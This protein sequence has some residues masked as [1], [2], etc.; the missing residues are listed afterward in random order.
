MYLKDVFKELYKKNIILVLIGKVL[1]EKY[2]DINIPGVYHINGLSKSEIFDCYVQADGFINT[3]E[4]EGM[5]N[6]ILEAMIM[7]CPVFARNIYSNRVIIKH[8]YNGYIFDSP[9]DFLKIYNNETQKIVNNAYQYIVKYHNSE[10]EKKRY[11]NI[12]SKI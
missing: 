1:E 8:E 12:I 4:S 11:A 5:S 10:L 3:S 9:D 6:A 7:K 2:N